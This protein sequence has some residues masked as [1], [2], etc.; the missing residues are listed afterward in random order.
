MKQVPTIKWPCP[1]PF[2]GH[3]REEDKR[4]KDNGKPVRL[5]LWIFLSSLNWLHLKLVDIIIWWCA[6]AADYLEKQ[7]KAIP[8]ILSKVKPKKKKHKSTTKLT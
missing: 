1:P 3:R 5:G 4:E 6:W 8:D 2:F 7:S